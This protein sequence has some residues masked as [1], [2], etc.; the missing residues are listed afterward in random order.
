M[1]KFILILS[2]FVVS[3]GNCFSQSLESQLKVIFGDVLSTHG[4]NKFSR[5]LGRAL[6]TSGTMQYEMEKIRENNNLYIT[7]ENIVHPKPGYAWANPNDNTDFRVRK[8]YSEPT[9]I[10]YDL[11]KKRKE[12]QKYYISTTLEQ[13]FLYKWED[14]FNENNSYSFSEFQGIKRSFIQGEEIK[15]FLGYTLCAQENVSFTIK[16]YFADDG[17]LIAKEKKNVFFNHENKSK[18]VSRMLRIRLGKLAPGKYMVTVN[19]NSSDKI[20]RRAK[21]FLKDHFEVLGHIN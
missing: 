20:D 7:S 6:Q 2:L 19:M 8:I 9:L 1:K 11:N 3:N 16:V 10:P 18:F 12:F 15:L 17:K 21:T 13:I 14:D 5:T 4:K